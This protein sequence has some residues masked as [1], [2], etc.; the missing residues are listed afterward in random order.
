MKK[1]KNIP[2][3]LK[4]Q[5]NSR[6]GLICSIVVMILLVFVFHQLDYQIIQKPADQAAKEAEQKKLE[7]EKAARAPEISTAT[8][9]AVGDN[10]YHDSLIPAHGTMTQSMKMSRAK[11]RR[12]IL[13]WSIRKLFSP[14]SMMQSVVI[15]PSQHLRKS[16]TH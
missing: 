11:F 15:H 14:Q 12:Q 10:L 1:N 16:A 13:P 8:V 7:A 4:E 6:I 2:L 9:I 5:I 3:N